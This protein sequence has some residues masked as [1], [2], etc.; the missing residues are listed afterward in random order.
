MT[1]PFFTGPNAPYR[2]VP[3]EPQYYQPWVFPIANITQ[4][5][6]A[7]VTTA[8]NNNYVVGQLVRFLI[9]AAYG[10]RQINEQ[11]AYVISL[12]ATN[13]FVVDLDTLQFDPFIPAPPIAPTPA[14]VVAVG[15]ENFGVISATGRIVASTNPP[16]AFIN[17]SPI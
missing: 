8:A 3:I 7:V 9:P 5:Q 13:Q 15:D 14:Q 1:S 2:N 10:M 16:G 6:T 12:L 4:A 11:T 17:I